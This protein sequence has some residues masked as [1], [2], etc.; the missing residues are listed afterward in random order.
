MAS[1][2]QQALATL[3]ALLLA[4]VGSAGA[5][6]AGAGAGGYT[7]ESCSSSDAER[8]DSASSVKQF[9]PPALDCPQAAPNATGGSVEVVQLFKP[10]SLP[11]NYSVICWK[12]LFGGQLQGSTASATVVAY[13]ADGALPGR[14]LYSQQASVRVQ[15]P[16]QWPAS[17][18]AAYQQQWYSAR[19]ALVAT[20]PRLFVGLRLA[21]TCASRASFLVSMYQDVSRAAAW[22][23][24]PSGAWT[25]FRGDWAGDNVSSVLVRL[26]GSALAA[27]AVPAGWSCASALY[28]DG[29]CHCNCGAWDADCALS[30]VSP[31]CSAGN[32]EVCNRTGLCQVV[33][34]DT[35]LPGCELRSFGAGDGC[36]CGCGASLDPDC[37]DATTSA[38][39]HPRALNCPGVSRCG[40]AGE[41]VA[42]WSGPA[43]PA[44]AYADGAVCDCSCQSGGV[45]DP[46]CAWASQSSPTCGA[47]GHCVLGACR[48]V[49]QAWAC[50]PD[51]W[52]SGDGCH[53]G[54]GA[55][56]PDC[57]TQTGLASAL[58]CGRGGAAAPRA[59]WSCNASGGCV[60]PGCGNGVVETSLEDCDGGTGCSAC[61]CSLGWAP[62]SPASAGCVPECGDGRV[63]GG[64]ECDGGAFC[65]ACRS[66]QGHAPAAPRELYCAGCGN[67][68][69]EEGEQCDSGP[70]C[71][72]D[73]CA[74]VAGFAPTSP[75]TTGCAASVANGTAHHGGVTAVVVLVA[76][77]VGGAAAVAV[78]GLVAAGLVA[79]RRRRGRAPNIP[80]DVASIQFVP[81]SSALDTVAASAALPLPFISTAT[82]AEPQGSSSSSGSACARQSGEEGDLCNV[83]GAAGAQSLALPPFSLSLQLQLTPT[84]ASCEHPALSRAACS[85]SAGSLAS[86][87]PGEGAAAAAEGALSHSDSLYPMDFLRSTATQ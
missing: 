1:E 24:G 56:D 3:L 60:A 76:A 13:E 44:S 38:A 12:S 7:P 10:R 22:R 65:A 58:G 45:A 78:A 85:A 61:H 39:W 72:P 49:P 33:E 52:G 80:I 36:Q 23:A 5:Q 50:A 64:E 59:A 31:N 54:C 40:D 9:L 20:A 74:C 14:L 19:L 70:G 17:S 15:A 84:L 11:W 53:C 42:A 81:E 51:A 8:Y 43:C 83:L 16:Q 34:W 63:V 71:A 55:P 62:T 18:W 87:V 79:A 69:L 32:H 68:R 4:A 2:A 25:A 29:V 48:A 66:A 41:C 82:L 35:G 26:R 27:P 30:P 47:A 46:D 86:P 37:R 73:T 67:G 57:A 77:P 28:K 21:G 6:G 75:L